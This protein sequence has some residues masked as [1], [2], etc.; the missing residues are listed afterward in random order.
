M[1]FKKTRKIAT[2]VLTLLLAFTFVGSLVEKVHAV[3]GGDTIAYPF[4]TGEEALKD[5]PTVTAPATNSASNVNLF[6]QV[7]FGKT[8]DLTSASY[9]AVQ[10]KFRNGDNPGIQYG[11]I[12]SDNAWHRVN[13]G[14][15]NREFYLVNEAG[16]VTATNILNGHCSV[17]NA[18]MVLIPMD[19]IIPD[20]GTATKEAISSF[21]MITDQMYNYNFQFRIGEIGYYTGEPSADTYT[22]IV[23]GVTKS[24]FYS[25]PELTVEFPTVE[26]P[27]ETL[28][29][30]TAT[31]PFSSESSVLENAMVWSTAVKSDATNWQTLKV[32]FDN[33]PA[34]LSDATYLAIQMK[35]VIGAP[36]LTYGLETGGLRYSI[37][38]ND[39]LTEN[40]YLLNK[41]GS[42]SLACQVQFGAA[43]VSGA[44]GCLLIPMEIIKYQFG[45]NDDA[46]LESVDH[47]VLTTNSFYN[48]GW[49]YMIGEVGYFTGEVGENL[50]FHKLVDLTEQYKPSLFTVSAD[51]SATAGTIRRNKI[52]KM[53]WGDTTLVYTAT[54]KA[55]GSMIPW[56]GGA[57]GSQTMTVDSYGDEALE[58]VCTG[59]REGADAYCAFTIGDGLTIDWSNAKGVTLWAKN[60]GD[61]EISF[62]FEMDVTSTETSIRARFNITQGNRFWLYD[63]NT[64]K[65]TIYM[66][67]PCV[68][69][70]AGFEGW[71][72]IP[73]E[74]FNQAQWSIDSAGAFPREHFLTA[75]SNVPYICITIYSGDY[76]NH[77]FAINKIGGYTT[78]PS[79]VSA[80][81][82]A[83]ET[84][85]DIAGLMGLN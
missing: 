5:A 3:A 22:K 26:E 8:V 40:V 63:V 9:L 24:N 15:N 55:S 80:L 43:T 41:D 23:D 49:E 64:G 19:L 37:A 72:R 34:D 10:I 6:F 81:V 31:Y 35:N 13:W 77:S 45:D 12:G 71:V 2:L 28:V 27:K 62:N 38:Q 21:Y 51:D 32:N 50:E 75:G 58:L 54:G 57:N 85:K 29:G 36:G 73:F 69:L 70:P 17:S 46:F 4:K 30:K 79:F 25:V 67:R 56:E 18:D 83:S 84:R 39:D 48:Y 60:L 52:D 76:T 11:L 53:V 74:A 33:G 66:T 68:T 65:Q 44:D 47:L 14:V 82:P 7:H 42:I 16:T 78:T 1:Y 61:K 20:N 59:A